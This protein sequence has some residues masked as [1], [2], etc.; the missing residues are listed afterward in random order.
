MKIMRFVGP[1]DG[2]ATA[3]V[4]A[5][6]KVTSKFSHTSTHITHSF[7]FMTLSGIALVLASPLP[8]AQRMRGCRIMHW[9]ETTWAMLLHMALLL[10]LL[11]LCGIVL[12]RFKFGFQPI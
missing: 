10:T 6:E 9:A 1:R 4:V 2:L 5:S 12:V 8:L 11:M 3:V 7:W